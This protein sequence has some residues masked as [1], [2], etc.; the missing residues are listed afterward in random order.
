MDV[1]Y[2]PGKGDCELCGD[3]DGAD[4]C[5]AKKRF[6]GQISGNVSKSLHREDPRGCEVPPAQI[7]LTEMLRTGI[8]SATAYGFRGRFSAPTPLNGET[9]AADGM[10]KVIDFH[11]SLL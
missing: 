2:N 3:T 5:V 10:R 7:M 8:P 11:F 1:L 9:V 6:R 4:G